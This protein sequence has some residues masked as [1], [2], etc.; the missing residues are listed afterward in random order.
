MA[1]LL[2]SHVVVCNG[3]TCSASGAEEVAL[4]FE[5]ALAERGLLSEVK[6]VRTG[7]MGACHLGPVAMVYPDG[8]LYPELSPEG[9]RTVV[10]EHLLKGRIVERITSRL[11][12][13]D[14]TVPSIAD[15]P[16]F[17]LQRK[18]VLRNCGEIDPTSIHEY[19]ARDGYE[20]LAK[21]VTEM[22]PADVIR[23]VKES[24]LR[25]RGG[26]GFPTGLK[27]EAVAREEDGPKQVLCIADERDLGP[28]VD[29]SI[30]ESDPHAIVEGMAIAGYA[31]GAVRGWVRLAEEPTPAA[32]RISAAVAD[33]RELGLLGQDILGSGF[34]FDITV[35]IGAADTP[36]WVDQPA[37]VA[38]AREAAL[39]PGRPPVAANVESWEGP[40]LAH[41]V[42]TLA[43]LAPIMLDSAEWMSGTEPAAGTGT[44]VFV[45]AGC[46]RNTGLVEVPLGTSLRAVIEEIG[47]GPR[48]GRKLKAVLI[49][50]PWGACI[51]E[52]QLDVPL[53]YERL[54]KL[55][56]VLGTGGLVAVDEGTCMADLAR[57]CLDF[58]RRE[59]CEKCAPCRIGTER[60][61]DIVTRV[62]DGRGRVGDIEL[63]EKVGGRL[64]RG[65][66]C[67]VG[68]AAARL[69]LDTTARFRQEYED[70]I[71]RQR[72]P[73]GTCTENHDAESH[74]APSA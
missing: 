30:L 65:S 25:G 2:R 18:V 35:L 32:E 51:P 53:D 36:R 4:A 15:V 28:L 60:M 67:A 12:G 52:G 7:C 74:Q 63:F 41:H 5:H 55:G 70:H 57:F 45:L 16:F 56:A 48:D 39:L 6:V 37:E 61:L 23:T 50:G 66:L 33:A 58:V 20:A 72:C 46:I 59:P 64:S 54:P 17:A 21:V 69:V 44:K 3:S 11:T 49:G 19:I 62:C 43:N 27:W 68:H 14:V 71:R 47:G 34:D 10:E 73:A 26:G 22:T 38:D 9:A 8:V 24:G 31:I 13:E 40:T 42:E 29:R 1:K